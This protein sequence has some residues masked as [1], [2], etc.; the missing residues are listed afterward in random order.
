[1]RASLPY[2]SS[3]IGE[4]AAPEAFVRHL[5]AARPPLQ[6]RLEVSSVPSLEYIEDPVP[7]AKPYNLHGSSCADCDLLSGRKY[8]AR[9]PLG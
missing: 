4:K 1:M 8:L 2:L 7:S 6:S 9:V 3:L 5:S